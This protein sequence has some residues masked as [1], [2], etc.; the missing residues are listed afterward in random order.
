MNWRRVFKIVL[1]YA[2]HYNQVKLK[3]GEGTD[4]IWISGIYY[5]VSL[6][7]WHTDVLV[8]TALWPWKAQTGFR[9]WMPKYMYEWIQLPKM[10]WLWW[11]Y[12]FWKCKGQKSLLHIGLCSCF[13]LP[14]SVE[15][16]VHCWKHRFFWHSFVCFMSDGGLGWFVLFPWGRTVTLLQEG[17]MWAL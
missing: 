17:T 2:V 8:P 9:R 15:K 6:H 10:Y 4:Q 14:L 13:D 16:D 11:L 1:Q 3:T 12:W 5:T 7:C